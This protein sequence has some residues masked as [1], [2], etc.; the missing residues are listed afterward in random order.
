MREDLYAADSERAIN[1]IA[2]RPTVLKKQEPSFSAWGMV[3]GLGKS[4]PAGVAET[5]GSGA[6]I[7]K[8][9]GQVSAATQP[10]TMFGNV[11]D[12][13]SQEQDAARQKMQ[14]DGIDMNSNIGRSFRNAAQEF[15]PDPATAHQSEVIVAEFGRVMTKAI[16]STLLTGTPIPAALEEGFTTSD[17]LQNPRDGRAP[18]DAKTA[19]NVGLVTAAA[20]AVAF[21]L[22][23]AGQTIKATVGLAA[24]SGPTTYIAQEAATREILQNANYDDLAV[25][26]DPFNPVGLGLA[27]LGSMIPGGVVLGLRARSAAQAARVAADAVPAELPPRTVVAQAVDQMT[28]DAARVQVLRNTIDQGRL[29]PAEDLA[30]GAAHRRAMESAQEQL[31]R[32]EPVNVARDLPESTLMRLNESKPFVEFVAKVEEVMA[33]ARPVDPPGVWFSSSTVRDLQVL[34]PAMA[35]DGNL[36]GPAVYMAKDQDVSA[37]YARGGLDQKTGERLPDGQVYAAEFQPTKP[38]DADKTMPAKEAMALAKAM[39]ADKLPGLEGK[40][41]VAGSTL[42]KELTKA[43]GGKAAVNKALAEQGYDAIMFKQRGAQLMAALREVSVKQPDA[44]APAGA[45]TGEPNAATAEAPRVEAPEATRGADAAAAPPD[46]PAAGRGADSQA[47]GVVPADGGPSGAA[48]GLPIENPGLHE[49]ATQLEA[50]NPDM[51]IR[52]D[53]MADDAPPITVAELMR[54]IREEVAQDLA[55]VPLIQTAATCFLTNGGGI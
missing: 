6:D 38:F 7:I 50:T 28:V 54:T 40:P 25:Q 15:M 23:V 44:P 19:N 51:L 41:R 2:A 8:G 13:Q 39:G 35:R 14:A 46:I 18:V 48:R 43:L 12:K 30:G 29:S 34:D 5:I 4:V 9:Y 55:E 47:A 53:G 10:A 20:N 22:P 37:T 26:H 1:E 11:T 49:M 27:T 42:Y 3:R 33:S 36:Y 45:R 52:I 17:K 32:G 16:G 24:V 31:A 21:G